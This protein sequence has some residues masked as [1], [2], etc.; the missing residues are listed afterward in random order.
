MSNYFPFK[1]REIPHDC[2]HCGE[3]LRSGGGRVG[4]DLVTRFRV[5]CLH[6]GFSTPRTFEPEKIQLMSPEEAEAH[7]AQGIKAAFDEQT[8]RG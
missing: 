7:I 2:P 8:G 6:C 5:G 3:R 4:D 1:P